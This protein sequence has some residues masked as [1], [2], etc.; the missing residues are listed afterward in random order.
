[1]PF[2]REKGKKGDNRGELK[3]DIVLEITY[4]CREMK[5]SEVKIIYKCSKMK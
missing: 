1:V 4:K 5:K 3:K 2:P